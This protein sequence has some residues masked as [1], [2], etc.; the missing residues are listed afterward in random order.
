MTKASADYEGRWR[1]AR[2][3]RATAASS[4]ARSSIASAT[5]WIDFERCKTAVAAARRLLPGLADEETR[6]LRAASSPTGT[7]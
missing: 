5:S 1:A 3:S 2:R 7:S 4:C 6:R